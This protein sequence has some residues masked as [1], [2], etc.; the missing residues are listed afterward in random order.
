MLDNFLKNMHRVIVMRSG[1]I[2]A[3]I[4][5]T[6]LR[7]KWDGVWPNRKEPQVDRGVCDWYL[8]DP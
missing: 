3:V 1:W 5:K 7:A 8:R 2:D 6:L 4:S